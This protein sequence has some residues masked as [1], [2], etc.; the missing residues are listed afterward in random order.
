MDGYVRERDVFD[1]DIFKGPFVEKLDRAVTDNVGREDCILRYDGGIASY[2]ARQRRSRGEA[3]KRRHG[4][5][6]SDMVAEGFAE[7]GL[8]MLQS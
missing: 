8:Y 3:Q 7:T 5:L 6:P 2:S 1:F 4:I